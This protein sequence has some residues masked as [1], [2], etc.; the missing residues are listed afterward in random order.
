[1]KTL[2]FPP[3]ENNTN[4]TNC[5]R[6]WRLFYLAYKTITHDYCF[7]EIRGWGLP[8]VESNAVIITLGKLKRDCEFKA[9]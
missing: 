1:M 5:L 2:A 3:R 9:R 8:S 4:Q 6:K 7:K